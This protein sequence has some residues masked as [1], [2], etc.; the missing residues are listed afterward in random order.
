MADRKEI[1]MFLDKMISI[2]I[3]EYL[4]AYGFQRRK[5]SAKYIRMIG[6]TKQVIDMNIFVKPSYAKDVDAHIYPFLTIIMPCCK[7]ILLCKW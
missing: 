4:L 6:E 5:N 1:L 3:D 7:T 2:K